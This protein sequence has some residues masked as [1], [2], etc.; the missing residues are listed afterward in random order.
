M[1]LDR[2]ASRQEA[3]AAD[4]RR[5]VTSEGNLQEQERRPEATDQA[6]DRAPSGFG[7]SVARLSA[8]CRRHGGAKLV[9]HLDRSTS[10]RALGLFAEV[11]ELNCKVTPR[12]LWAPPERKWPLETASTLAPALALA[13]AGRPTLAG[14]MQNQSIG[15]E[16]HRTRAEWMPVIDDGWWPAPWPPPPLAPPSLTARQLLLLLCLPQVVARARAN[17]RLLKTRQTTWRTIIMPLCP[18]LATG[19]K[20]AGSGQSNSRRESAKCREPSS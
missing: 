12:P 2:P 20:P 6:C 14:W 10:Q 18:A 19:N 7:A 5:P 15:G 8:F 1:A 9:A 17:F 3:R 11:E 16:L 4:F 13:L